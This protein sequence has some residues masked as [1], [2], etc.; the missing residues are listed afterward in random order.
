M[1]DVIENGD[2]VSKIAE[3]WFLRSQIRYIEIQMHFR[4]H[5]KPKC[6]DGVANAKLNW[7]FIKVC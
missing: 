6:P 4:D 7:L 3:Q 5:A 2:D 1:I